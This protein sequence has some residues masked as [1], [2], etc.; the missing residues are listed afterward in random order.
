MENQWS[1]GP[2]PLIL[3]YPLDCQ[4]CYKHLQTTFSVLKDLPSLESIQCQKMPTE[5]GVHK[6]NVRWLENALVTRDWKLSP[7]RCFESPAESWVCFWKG[8]SLYPALLSTVQIVQQQWLEELCTFVLVPQRSRKMRPSRSRWACSRPVISLS[9][10]PRSP[11][12]RFNRRVRCFRLLIVHLEV[13]QVW[14][15]NK[16]YCGPSSSNSLYDLDQHNAH[17]PSCQH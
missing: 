17:C 10:K 12:K 4:C 2:G 1:A 3:N 6:P 16:M 15:A 5:S 9:S 13:S 7:C 8:S 14:N 11:A